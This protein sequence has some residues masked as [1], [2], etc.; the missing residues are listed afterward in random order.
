MD[1]NKTKA[2]IESILQEIEDAPVECDGFCLIASKRLLESG[3]K[4]RK[5]CG[6]I[7]V[8]GRA[9]QHIWLQHEELIID[10]RA[11]MWL[12]SSAPHG[13]FKEAQGYDYT[14]EELDNPTISDFL[15]VALLTPFTPHQQ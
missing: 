1:I 10:Y 4:T 13:V 15:E 5:F 12:G 11:R 7:N 9:I 14:G 8:R 3:I 2:R 6:K